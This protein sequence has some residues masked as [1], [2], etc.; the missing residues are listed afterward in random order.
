VAR[1]GLPANVTLTR[2]A[3]ALPDGINANQR[4]DLVPGQS[5]YPANQSPTLWLNPLA[6]TTPA[7]GEW[8]NASRNIVRVPGI[9]QADVSR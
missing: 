9:W 1:T 5:L 6:F 4:P 8:G 3:S 7:N 2:N